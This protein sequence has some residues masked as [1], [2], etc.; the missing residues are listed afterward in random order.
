MSKPQIDK[1]FS[2]LAFV[3]RLWLRAI[4]EGRKRAASAE[5][6]QG[7]ADGGGNDTGLAAFPQIPI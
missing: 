3:R 4:L 1:W 6:R 7:I 5:A 2:R